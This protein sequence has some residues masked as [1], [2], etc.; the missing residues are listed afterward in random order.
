MLGTEE[1]YVLLPTNV[2]MLGRSAVKALESWQRWIQ[3][4]PYLLGWLTFS[5]AKC[6]RQAK[7]RGMERF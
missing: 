5:F 7:A 3:T 1:E 2:A 4:P 6:R